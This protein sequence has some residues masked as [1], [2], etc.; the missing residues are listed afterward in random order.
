MDKKENKEVKCPKCG[1]AETDKTMR[2]VAA[3]G[4]LTKRLENCYR[5]FKC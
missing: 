2:T 3:T 4:G 5:R 1:A